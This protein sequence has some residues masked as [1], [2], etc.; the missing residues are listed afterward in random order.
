MQGMTSRKVKKQ[1]KPE[2][3]RTKPLSQTQTQTPTYDSVV[4]LPLEFVTFTP[5][6]LALA[7]MLTRFE[8]DTA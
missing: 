7:M 2:H 5:R 1:R 6:A 8:E 3:N 4:S